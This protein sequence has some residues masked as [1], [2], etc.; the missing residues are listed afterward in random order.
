M[1]NAKEIIK[2]GQ[3][4]IRFLLESSDTNNALTMFEF[5]VP[6]GAKVPL[7]HYHERFDET[8]YGLKGVMT[9]IVDGKT[10]ELE[11]GQSIFISKDVVHGFNNLSQHNAT[12]LAVITPGLL[13]AE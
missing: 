7:P 2:E 4:E 9:F 1:T 12:S 13:G 8:I 6:A 5:F 10:I 3:L 11:Q